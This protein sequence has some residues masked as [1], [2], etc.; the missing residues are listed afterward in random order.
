MRTLL[1]LTALSFL[2]SGCYKLNDDDWQTIVD[3]DGDGDPSLQY[4]GGDCDDDDKTIHSGVTEICDG[5]DNDCD[6]ETDEADASDAS[7]W[8]ADTDGDGYGDPDAPTVACDQ[9]SGYVVDDTDCDDSDALI[10]PETWWYADADSD[11]YGKPD[12]AQQQCEQPSGYVLDDTDCD[13]TAND[14]NPGEDE[15]C[16]EID[17]DCD[18]DNGML[19]VDGD[20]WAVCEGDCDDDNQDIF[21]GADEYCNE[22]DDDCDE[23]IDED[24]SLDAISWY[25]DA[26]GDDY[27]AADNALIQCYQ[28]KGYVSDNTDC[29]DGDAAQYPGA[30]EYCNFEDDDCDGDEDEDDSAD[31][32]TWYA[33]SDGDG[34]GDAATSSVACYESSGW[35]SDDTDCDDGDATQ[36]PGADEYCNGEDD[37][38][39]ASVDEDDAQDASTWYV[40]TDGDDYGTTDS[41]LVACNQPKGYV[42]SD[43]DCDDS[44]SAINPGADEICNEIDDN[45]DDRVDGDDSV[46]ATT[47]YEDD[48][49]DGYGNDATGFTECLQPANTVDLGGDCDDTDPDVNPDATEVCDAVDNDCDASNDYDVIVDAAGSTAYSTINDGIYATPSSGSMCILDGTY[50]ET[51]VLDK[52]ITMDGES[53]EGVILDGDG[54]GSVLTLFELN[55]TSSTEVSNLS[56]TGGIGSDGAALY[57]YDSSA[58][59]FDILI[60]DNNGGGSSGTYCDGTIVHVDDSSTL[61]IDGIEIRDN[62]S[63]C[64]NVRGEI[65]VGRGGE[66]AM[67]HLRMT[68]NTI[69]ADNSVEGMFYCYEC[70]LSLTNAIIA[71]NAIQPADSFTDIVVDAGVIDATVATVDLT[72]VTIHD[73]HVQAGAGGSIDAG[74][75]RGTD[76]GLS[77]ELTSVSS[78]SVSPPNYASISRSSATFSYCNFY[79]YDSPGF[80]YGASP[81]GG[82]TTVLDDPLFVDVSDPDPANWDLHLQSGSPLIDAGPSTTSDAD[83]TRA[84]IGAYGGPGSDW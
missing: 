30:T 6:G 35:V 2:A 41:V 66:L 15:Q 36:H 28:P 7:T 51:V 13:D 17:H 12:D 26:D 75:L 55:S 56:L 54:S 52:E 53:M 37:D 80:A 45:C 73:I 40:D 78:I 4:D 25:T 3:R 83:G 77:F 5:I 16:D 64:G 24:D 27:G 69:I 46:D 39:D 63:D 34:W 32:L 62:I 82:A 70:V 31:A 48:D 8:Y 61:L 9:P 1:T 71:G 23:Q 33:D 21:P 10:H 44:D 60:H 72:N 11:G 50:V 79:D 74:V 42:S 81:E 57:S 22:D 19:D 29:D 49:G 47:W 76:P 59:L 84:D 18:D 68:G 43:G 65:H 20:G 67:D 14:V 58:V 38:C